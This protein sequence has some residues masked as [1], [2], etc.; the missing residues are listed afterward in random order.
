LTRASQTLFPSSFL[1]LHGDT[2]QWLQATLQFSQFR[3]CTALSPFT[4]PLSM[5]AWCF[6]LDPNFAGNWTMQMERG[7]QRKSK[8]CVLGLPFGY[9]E[10]RNIPSRISRKR[11]RV[12]LHRGTLHSAGPNGAGRPRLQPVLVRTVANVSFRLF[13]VGTSNRLANQNLGYAKTKME[14]ACLANQHR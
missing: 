13:W 6:L 8:H 2:L 4:M 10:V 7:R 5:P 3:G 12:T 1:F 9:R 14:T 11:T